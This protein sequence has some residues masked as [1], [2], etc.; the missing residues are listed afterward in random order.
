MGLELCRAKEA[1]ARV[2]EAWD[3]V[4]IAEDKATESMAEAKE[5]VEV[6]HWKLQNAHCRG[7]KRGLGGEEEPCLQVGKESRG[8]LQ[9]SER[10]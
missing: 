2:E 5:Q 1:D 6:L 9:E 8:L 10:F 7:G 3:M 4:A